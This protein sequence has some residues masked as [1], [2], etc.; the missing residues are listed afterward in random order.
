MVNK[1]FQ[2]SFERGLRLD[3]DLSAHVRSMLRILFSNAHRQCAVMT[4]ESLT[5]SNLNNEV[6][7]TV[8]DYRSMQ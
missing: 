3:H 8:Y 7:L 5:H 4:D 6:M 1:D 2:Y